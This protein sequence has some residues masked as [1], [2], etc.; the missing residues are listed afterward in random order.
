MKL[1]RQP[2]KNKSETEFV[3]TSIYPLTSQ[4]DSYLE[5][6]AESLSVTETAYAAAERSYTSL[7][8]WL[9]RDQSSVKAYN[10]K[11]YVQGSFAL[12]TTLR[13]ITEDGE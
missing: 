9:C 10:P 1:N 4:A 11:V 13:P 7:G 3:M 2:Y 8:N 6:L 12:G 5:E